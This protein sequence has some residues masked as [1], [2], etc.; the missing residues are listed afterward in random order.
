M[1]RGWTT[2]ALGELCEITIGRTPSRAEPN[3]WD[4]PHPWLSI[5]DMGSSGTIDRTKEGVTDDAAAKAAG[6]LVPAGTVVLSFKLSIGKVGVTARPMF[7][8][9]AIAA[10]QPRTNNLDPGYLFHQLRNLDLTASANRAAMGGTLNKKTLAEIPLVL[11]PLDEQRRIAA[12]LDHVASIRARR[13]STSDRYDALAHL[14]FAKMTTGHQSATPL[15]DLVSRVVAGRN[16]VALSEQSSHPHYRV[17]PVGA[18]TFGSFRVDGLKRVPA[19]YVAPEDHFVNDGDLLFGR[20]NTEH[21]VGGVAIARGT[22][23]GTLL[24][25]KIWRIEPLQGRIERDYLRYAM[26]SPGFR[27]EVTRL[28]SGT[29]GSMKNISKEKFLRIAIPV[30]PLSAQRTFAEHTGHVEQLR[31]AAESHRGRLDALFVS[32]QARAFAGELDVDNVQLPPT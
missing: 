10:L 15:G 8:N 16:I 1:K 25:D 21:L 28:A 32:L 6:R 7:T 17:L 26:S 22:P 20:A 30:L 24:P 3:Y 23:T 31:Q 5:A 13:Q 2:A 9:E 29:S 11:P 19:D 18:V 27:R 12:V 4:G 14:L